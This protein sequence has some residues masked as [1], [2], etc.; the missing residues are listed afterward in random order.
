MLPGHTELGNALRARRLDV[1]LLDYLQHT[2]THDTRDGCHRVESQS[3]RRQDRV[4]EALVLRDRE[5]PPF[6]CKEML[7]QRAHD[8]VRD[9]CTKYSYNHKD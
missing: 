1:I 5:Q 2:R 6:D 4:G 3:D 9:T 7:Q 8:K